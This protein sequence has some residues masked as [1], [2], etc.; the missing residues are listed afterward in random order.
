MRESMPGLDKKKRLSQDDYRN[1]IG[2]AGQ[3]ADVF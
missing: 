3:E 2:R 1:V